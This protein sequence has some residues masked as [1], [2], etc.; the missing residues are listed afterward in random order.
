MSDFP[1]YNSAQVFWHK[2]FYKLN[3][4][5]GKAFHPKLSYV[6]PELTAQES[7]D[8]IY[9]L[10]DSGKP[11]MIAKYGSTE[12]YCLSNYLGIQQGWKNAI[13]FVMGTAEPWWW[14]PEK[15]N[16]MRDNAGFS[17]LTEKK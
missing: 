14:A 2:A 8:L 11:C 6:R 9:A 10:L 12:F 17:P 5:Y 1:H 16:N 7:S 3:Y 4:L 15:V 13:G